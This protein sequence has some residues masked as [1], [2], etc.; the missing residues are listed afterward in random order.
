MKNNIRSKRKKTGGRYKKIKN[1]R[2]VNKVGIFY[3]FI[4]KKESL[5]YSQHFSKGRSEKKKIVKILKTNSKNH[6]VRG[7]VTKG[8]ILELE[9]NL[10]GRVVSKHNKSGIIQTTGV[11]DKKLNSKK[12]ERIIDE[13]LKMKLIKLHSPK[14]YVN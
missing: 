6:K 10:I 4:L 12:L 13:D 2:R 3:P 11:I 7:I 1:V 9:D 5:Y 14:K 8:T